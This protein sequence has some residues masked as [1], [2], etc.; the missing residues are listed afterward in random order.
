MIDN[1]ELIRDRALT[2]ASTLPWIDPL[3]VEVREP[4]V[5][6]VTQLGSGDPSGYRT[7]RIE[8]KR[9]VDLRKRSI[10]SAH[11][12][13]AE[14]LERHYAKPLTLDVTCS[15]TDVIRHN[16]PFIDLNPSVQ[17]LPK[18]SPNASFSKLTATMLERYEPMRRRAFAYVESTRWVEP[19]VLYEH[20][21]KPLI[22]ESCGSG[23]LG[24]Y[25]NFRFELWKPE[26]E[27][28]RV[29]SATLDAPKTARYL[30]APINLDITCSAT[31]V[32]ETVFDF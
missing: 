24:D 21:P 3:I 16:F 8:M 20:E 13:D 5:N 1:A 2:F 25:R 28:S 6:I 4:D 15:A 22:V 9:S 10:E 7:A 14:F 27:R 17:S 11:A 31:D 19:V 23:D 18:L 26:N 30:D 12:K 29:L 32:I